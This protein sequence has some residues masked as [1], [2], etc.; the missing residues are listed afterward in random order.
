MKAFT[1][2]QVDALQKRSAM[3]KLWNYDEG[4]FLLNVWASWQ[5]GYALCVG[6]QPFPVRH[7]RL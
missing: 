6:I 7:V 1:L 5:L 4:I 2:W 3:A